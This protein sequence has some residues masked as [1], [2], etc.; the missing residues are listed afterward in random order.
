MVLDRTIKECDELKNLMNLEFDKL[1]KDLKQKFK[2]QF[3]YSWTLK[4][5]K[6]L[7]KDRFSYDNYDLDE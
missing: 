1:D 7:Y 2:R 3:S 6:P 4:R 5:K